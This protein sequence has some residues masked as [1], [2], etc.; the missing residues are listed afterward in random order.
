MSDEEY[1]EVSEEGCRAYFEDEKGEW[2]SLFYSV[3][4]L[5]QVWSNHSGTFSGTPFVLP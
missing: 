2:Q 1:K 4:I 3:N 5:L